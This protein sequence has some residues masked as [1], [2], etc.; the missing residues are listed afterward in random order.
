MWK[1]M[2]EN[3]ED[4]LSPNLW[5]SVACET[6]GT[7]V[8]V[9]MGCGTLITSDPS[10][11][12]VQVALGFGLSVA[13]MVWVFG[14]I[15]GGHFNPALSAAAVVTRRVSIVRGVLYVLGQV[16]GGI[17]GAGTIYGLTPV[18]MQGSL[19]ATR[20]EDGGGLTQAQGFGVEAVITFVFVLA[21]FACQDRERRDLQGST[22]LTVGL[23]VVVCHLFAVS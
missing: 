22:P 1:I 15:S 8:I 2:Q 13:T 11:K 5:R 4:L 17:L 18:S 19:G 21:F 6:L 9:L 3:L 10:A 20:L 16:V 7:L 12:T 23:A 14:H